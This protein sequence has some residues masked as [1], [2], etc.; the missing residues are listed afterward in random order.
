MISFWCV[1]A[2]GVCPDLV[3]GA[4]EGKDRG[5]TNHFIIV[6]YQPPLCNDYSLA[7]MPI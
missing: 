7:P 1:K 5:S 2:N 3:A 4:V 6:N